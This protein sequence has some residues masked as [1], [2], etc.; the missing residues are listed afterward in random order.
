MKRRNARPEPQSVYIGF[1]VGLSTQ[2]IDEWRTGAKNQPNA[3][4][5]D[6]RVTIDGVEREF[7]FEDFKERL[8]F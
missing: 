1:T 5:I 6:C 3:K 7:T 8:G 2:S 4:V